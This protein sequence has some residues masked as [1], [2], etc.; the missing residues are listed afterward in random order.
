M[1]TKIEWTDVSWNPV[2]GCSAGCDYCYAR[3]MARRLQAMGQPRYANGFAPTF[4]PEVLA[5]PLHWRKPRRVFVVSMGDL[6]DRVI[7]D[8]QITSVFGVVAVCPQH[9][10]QVLTKRPARM[11][12]WFGKNGRDDFTC[13]RIAWERGVRLPLHT[14]PQ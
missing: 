14:E 10:F 12:Q 2:T 9:T 11:R 8:S 13:Q 1:T 6:F 4:H 7:T 5:E 3:R